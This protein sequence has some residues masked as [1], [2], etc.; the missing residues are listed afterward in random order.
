MAKSKDLRESTMERDAQRRTRDHGELD[1]SESQPTPGSAEG[2]RDPARQ[3][4]SN[5]PRA[6]DEPAH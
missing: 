5:V 6:D 2:E 4:E 3:S 1:L